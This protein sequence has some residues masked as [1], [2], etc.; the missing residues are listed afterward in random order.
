MTSNANAA[1]ATAAV[2]TPEDVRAGTYAE[3]LYGYGAA[4]GVDL[5][6]PRA[7]SSPAPGVHQQL[8]ERG[9]TVVNTT[10]LP[11]LV[12]LSQPRVDLDDTLR[13]AVVLRP[14][15][16]EVLRDL[17]GQVADVPAGR[18]PSRRARAVPAPGLGA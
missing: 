4:P 5:G 16:A 15:S 12:R 2:A 13:T 6:H 7:F 9:L 18:Q 17:D 10:A 3:F 14:H 1:V 11:V 8:F